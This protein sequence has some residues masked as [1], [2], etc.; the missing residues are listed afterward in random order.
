VPTPLN[1]KSTVE[2][3]RQRF[4]REVERFSSL[5]SG[6]IATM[7]A[8]LAMELTARAA[9]AATPAIRHV[10]DVGCGAGNST[11]KL[12]LVYGKDFAVDLLDLSR[13]MLDRARQRVAA[14][15]AGPV[16]CL[17]GDFREIRL[18]TGKYDVVLAAAVLHHLR[19]DSD[20]R[21]AFEKIHR[22]LA[23]GGSVW[24]T[25]LVWHE[26][27]SVQALMWE[28]YGEYLTAVGGTDYRDRVWA[29]IDREDSPRPVTWQ[30]DLLRAVGFQQV[31]VLHKNGCFA[32]FGAV[33]GVRTRRA[34][35][36]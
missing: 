12:C 11:I 34:S 10:L 24:I 22:V 29:Y 27:Q 30:L 21:A 15:N 4:D 23:P 19:D 33:Q 13:P 17:A 9:V 26:S 16:R 3:I 28:R 18:P 25:D 7:D 8:P 1:R 35:P 6:Q 20:W 2:E 32:T 14:V 5:D 36:P 31:D